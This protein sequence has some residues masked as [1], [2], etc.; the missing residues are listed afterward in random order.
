MII[1]LGS[2]DSGFPDGFNFNYRK[3]VDSLIEQVVVPILATKA[4]R[5]EGPE[6]F[7]NEIIRTI[8]DDLKVPL[9]EFDLIAD[10][11]PGRGLSSD[12]VHLTYLEPLDYTKPEMF[13]LG[14]P[15]HNL[16]SLMIL[17]EVRRE[18]TN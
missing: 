16:A 9:L 17:D 12:N 10:T 13:T 2:N 14:Y 6:N 4:D 8:A 18:L 1:Y 15:V 7:N 3:I 5:F 11:L